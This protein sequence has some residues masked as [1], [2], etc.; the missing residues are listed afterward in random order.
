MF[1]GYALNDIVGTNAFRP[2]RRNRVALSYE[3]AARS[4]AAL[5]IR[6]RKLANALAGLGVTAGDT[7][8]V[9]MGN[10]HEWPEAL[11]AITSLSAVCAPINVLL[12]GQDVAQV[13]ADSGAKALIADSAAR[14]ALEAIS[15]L[16]PILVMVDEFEAP[17]GGE[18]RAYEA[19]VE[20]ASDNPTASR[21]APGAPSMMYYT[22]GT[23]GAPKGA[24]HSQA[25][26]LWNSYHQIADVG[27]SENDVYL[28]VPSLS[29]AAGF[30]DVML[31]LMWL[32]GRVAMLPTGGLTID[33]ILSAVEAEG[34]THTLLVPTLLKQLD[35]TPGGYERIRN[36]RLRRIFTGAEPAPPSLIQRINSELPNCRVIQ[37]YGMSE[38]PLMMTAMSSEDALRLPDRAGRP[39]SI[40]TLGVRDAAGSISAR[41]AGE[42]VIRSPAT[43]LGYHN[44]PE[45]TAEALRDGWFHTGDMGEIDDEGYL[46]LTGRAK[47]MIISGGMNVYAREIEDLILSIANV[48]DVAVVGVPD[49]KWGET[50]VAIIVAADSAG[51]RGE[52]E[53]QCARLSSYKRPSAVL[54]R[55]EP[56]PRTPTGKVLKRE[57]RPWAGS[58][59]N[60]SGATQ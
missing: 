42:V 43:M 28:L 39:T 4:F 56:L 20:R 7:V 44:R 31:A 34:V 26:I 48:R 53:A 32:G 22:S 54:I 33:R 13:L 35:N 52:V 41:G 19:I 2:D 10:R 46:R 55:E 30:H 24:T 51:L 12:N 9:L 58:K 25:G 23:T 59:L 16:P 8:A 57:L 5:D 36:S 27:L 3:G 21:P 50:P 60:K 47:D 15:D 14:R 40:V 6:A 38:F 11:F 29:W 17:A 37:L 49:D 1:A 18:W 45:A